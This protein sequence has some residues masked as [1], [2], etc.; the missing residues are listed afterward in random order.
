MLLYRAPLSELD[1]CITNNSYKPITN[2]AWVRTRLYELQ[3]GCIRLATAS[4]KVYQLLSHGRWFSPGSPASS[5]T[6]TGSHDIAEILLKVAL[7]TINQIN[8]SAYYCKKKQIIN[9]TFDDNKGEKRSRKPKTDTQNVQNYSQYMKTKP[10]CS[11]Q[12]FIRTKMLFHLCRVHCMYL[13]LNLLLFTSIYINIS[14][15][16]LYR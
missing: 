5:T 15:G 16:C 14:N 13:F 7:N 3:K 9:K 11:D 10:V 2:T 8:K 6:K 1:S 12:L 4:D